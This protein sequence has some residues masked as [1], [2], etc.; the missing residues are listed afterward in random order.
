[1]TLV[2][3]LCRTIIFRCYRGHFDSIIPDAFLYSGGHAMSL[4][5]LLLLAPY[6][7]TG[8]DLL[9]QKTPSKR[10]ESVPITYLKTK[11]FTVPKKIGGIRVPK[12]EIWFLLSLDT[13][14]PRSV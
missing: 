5:P 10:I 7:Q 13:V 6:P 12:C 3:L 8:T 11:L 14:T 2:L 4:T 1:M 9:L